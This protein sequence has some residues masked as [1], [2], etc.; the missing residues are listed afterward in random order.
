MSRP[1]FLDQEFTIAQERH[2]KYI[3]IVKTRFALFRPYLMVSIHE[4]LSSSK[5]YS[6]MDIV[7]SY[8]AIERS[9]AFSKITR[10]DLLNASFNKPPYLKF[11]NGQLKALHGRHRIQAASKALFPNDRWWIVDLY[12]DGTFQFLN[13]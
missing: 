12:L 2:S 9:L 1:G 10:A 6:N 7:A 4:D 11:P 13:R 5:R 3:S 8:K